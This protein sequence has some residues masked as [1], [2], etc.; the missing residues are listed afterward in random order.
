MKCCHEKIHWTKRRTLLVYRSAASTLCFDTNSF[1]TDWSLHQSELSRRG[2]FRPAA[3]G[4]EK[5]QDTVTFVKRCKFS[6]KH[7][8]LSEWFLIVKALVRRF[9]QGK[10]PS[11]GL[12]QALWKF[13]KFR[14]QLYRTASH[15][16][17]AVSSLWRVSRHPVSRYSLY[18]RPTEPQQPTQLQVTS[19]NSRG[20][21]AA[22]KRHTNRGGCVIDNGCNF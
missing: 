13:A 17:E 4:G 3:R 18:S 8:I 15:V 20:H 11:R 14:W 5:C 1:S 21:V 9:Q 7:T 6:I 22:R 10:G 2:S 16:C 19:Q 12:L